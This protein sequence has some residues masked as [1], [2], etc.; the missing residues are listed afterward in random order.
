MDDAQRI[1]TLKR[2]LRRQYAG[3]LNGLK[4]LADQVAATATGEVTL[5]GH[6]FEGG[7]ATG[8]VTFERLAY[9]AAVED[10]ITEQDPTASP[11][12]PNYA[13]ARFGP[14]GFCA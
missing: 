9:L 8:V 5:T 3:N 10:L 7:S 1:E 14:G 2:T 13:Y 6:T 11:P 4:T 12:A